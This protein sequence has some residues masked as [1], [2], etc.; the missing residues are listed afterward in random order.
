MFVFF[1]RFFFQ[2]GIAKL[3]KEIELEHFF[4]KKNT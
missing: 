1:F 2:N 4:L 3:H